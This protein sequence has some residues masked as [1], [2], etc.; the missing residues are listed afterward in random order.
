MTQQ[1][2]SRESTPNATASSASG[3]SPHVRA[4]TPATATA[5]ASSLGSVALAHDAAFSNASRYSTASA[6]ESVALRTLRNLAVQDWVFVAYFSIFFVALVFGSGPNRAPQMMRVAG[7]LLVL[8]IGLIATRGELLQPGTRF[9]SL[10]YRLTIFGTVFL[11]YFQL[12]YILPGV[13]SRAVDAQILALD[14]RL[15]GFEPALVWD[16]FVTPATT[17]WFAF[18]YFGYFGLLALHILPFLLFAKDK[19]LT[20]RFSLG[21]YA[22]FCT[23]HIIYMLVPG[24]GPYRFLASEFQNQLSGGTFWHLVVQTVTGAGAQKDIFPSLHTAV[25]TYFVFFSFRNRHRA[26]FKYTWP[27]VAAFASQT[28][29]ATM[30]LRWH[31]LID[32]FAGIALASCA[33]V[34][35]TRVEAWERSRRTRLGLPPI[36]GPA[37]VAVGVART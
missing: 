19:D 18:F 4:G 27:L 25:P 14:M 31:Y 32:I 11:S 21:V 2:L 1:F 16:R 24:F 5:T 33:V 12:Q 28:V 36:F 30:F 3:R 26:P 29:I 15:F 37:P 6:I 22:V 10:V 8:A 20:A 9:S 34:A 23:A 35:S 13:S 17:E 7:D